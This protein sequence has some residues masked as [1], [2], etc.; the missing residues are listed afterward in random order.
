LMPGQIIVATL[1]PAVNLGSVALEPV[2]APQGPPVVPQIAQLQQA[3]DDVRVSRAATPN[4]FARTSQGL[5][6]GANDFVRTLNGRATVL[7]P[8]DQSVIT[9]TEGSTIQIQQQVRAGTVTR[10]ITQY[11]GTLWFR[12]Q[13]VTG[14]QT[15]LETPTAVA[16]IRGAAGVATASTVTTV[17]AVGAGAIAATTGAIA[18]LVPNVARQNETA[19]Q[20]IPLNPPGGGN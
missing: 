17:A 6:L 11:T 15:T 5:G 13:R 8:A 12:I 1:L 9:L 19:S 20:T 2:A 7:F 16:A 18:A 3:S 10:R 14:T 4:N